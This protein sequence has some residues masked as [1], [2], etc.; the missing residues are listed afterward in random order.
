[1]SENIN[2]RCVLVRSYAGDGRWSLHDSQ[3]DPYAEPL[4]SGSASL[5]D[6]EWSRPDK[7]DYDAANKKLKERDRMRPNAFWGFNHITWKKAPKY[8]YLTRVHLEVRRDGDRE[9]EVAARPEVS[10]HWEDCDDGLESVLSRMRFFDDEISAQDWAWAFRQH[11]PR[12]CIFEKTET[13][14]EW[15]LLYDVNEIKRCDPDDD[16]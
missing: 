12:A 14:N 11:A 15:V 7:D 3:D 8:L 10:P 13:P 1:M 4:L 6:G 5:I 9:Y 2:C 16:A